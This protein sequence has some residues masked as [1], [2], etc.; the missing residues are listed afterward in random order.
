[1]II[2]DVSRELRARPLTW[3]VTGAA[4]FIGSHLVENLLLLGQRVRGLDNFSTGYRENIEV[5]TKC[6][7]QAFDLVD[8]DIRDAGM[9][10][11]A[12]VGVNCVLHHAALASVSI[13]MQNPRETFDNNVSG[14]ITLLE[15]ARQNGVSRIVYASSSSVYGN[16]PTLPKREED[17]ALPL[18]PYA[19]TK[20]L[21]EE[22][23]EMY[24][25]VYGLPCVGLRYF[26]V[27]GDRQSVEGAYAS[28][29]PRWFDVLRRGE[30][31]VIYGDG[32]TTRDFCHVRDVVRANLLAAM[33]T[34]V[35]AYGT[36]FNVARG[37]RTTLNELFEQIHR[38]SGAS[39][40]VRLRYEP[41]REGE[42]RHSVACIRR[43]G[44][45]LGYE[46]SITIAD[47]LA[48]MASRR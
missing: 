7:P 42:V 48:M 45:I 2:D 25:R 12:T 1:M 33:T 29:I 30:W 23:A 13:S 36:V 35:E 32:E 4:G 17:L 43:A 26:N 15:A 6:A 47:G 11:R 9:C 8:G 16:G 37:E 41:F 27:F 10:L 46:P 39:A 18:S 28:V 34:A 19:L 22:S 44:R 40:D 21:N 20:R 3:L 31:A 5:A 14:F 24:T 38:L